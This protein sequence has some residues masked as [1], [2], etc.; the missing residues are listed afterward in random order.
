MY[1]HIKYRAE[2]IPP[3]YKEVSVVITEQTHIEEEFGTENRDFIHN[4]CV[5][6]SSVLPC[7]GRDNQVWVRGRQRASDLN[8]ILLPI[9]EYAR[10][11]EAVLAY[12]EHF[13][14]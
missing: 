5:L 2:L 11:K 13:K 6:S 3:S 12:N 8:P 10:F 4:G 7:K 1:K 9:G 14:E